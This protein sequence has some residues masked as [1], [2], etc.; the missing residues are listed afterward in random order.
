MHNVMAGVTDDV[1][2]WSPPLNS[3]SSFQSIPAASRV[4][5]PQWSPPV[6]GGSTCCHGHA[7]AEYLAAMGPVTERREYPIFLTAAATLWS[8][9]GARR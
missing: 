2:Q 8:R 5:A 7:A 3:G 4:S 9:D 6:N 1:P